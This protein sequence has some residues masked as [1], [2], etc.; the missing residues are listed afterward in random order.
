[1]PTHA[2]PGGCSS[3]HLVDHQHLFA[4]E[5][6]GV[7]RGNCVSGVVRNALARN[8]RYHGGNAAHEYST[9]LG[10]LYLAINNNSVTGF[11]V[12]QTVI[13]YILQNGVPGRNLGKSIIFRGVFPEILVATRTILYCPFAY[14]FRAIDC[15]LS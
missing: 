8:L 4:E 1:M 11:L 13:S 9:F 14:N 15:T 3:D 7:K 6:D 2:S 5:Q 12:E 10:S